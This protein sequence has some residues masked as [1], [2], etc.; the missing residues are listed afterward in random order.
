MQKIPRLKID[1]QENKQIRLAKNAQI[2]DPM[3]SI[4]QKY[5]GINTYTEK[6][7]AETIILFHQ[8]RDYWRFGRNKELSDYQ[9]KGN[10]INKNQIR[11]KKANGKSAMLL[12]YLIE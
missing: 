9:R 5:R 3:R 6:A 7:F 10:K 11:V 4:G 12:E 2:K 8:K 1:C